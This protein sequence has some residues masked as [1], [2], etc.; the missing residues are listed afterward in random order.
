MRM[1]TP[2]HAA[3]H[4]IKINGPHMRPCGC[5]L[6]DPFSLYNSHYIIFLVAH[7]ED[8]TNKITTTC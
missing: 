3:S 6:K 7:E 4:R 2:M 8:N 5:I 1:H